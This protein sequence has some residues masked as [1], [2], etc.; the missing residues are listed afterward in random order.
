MSKSIVVDVTAHEDDITDGPGLGI[1]IDAE[2]L[3]RFSGGVV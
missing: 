3:K 1:E 2:A